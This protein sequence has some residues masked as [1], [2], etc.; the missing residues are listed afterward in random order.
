MT[1]KYDKSVSYSMR[2]K[3]ISFAR[4]SR[5]RYTMVFMARQGKTIDDS[6]DAYAQLKVITDAAQAGTLKPWGGKVAELLNAY[7]VTIDRKKALKAEVTLSFPTTPKNRSMG[8]G[9]RHMKPDGRWAEDFFLFEE[10]VGLTCFY[11]GSQE[12][13]LP[14]YKGTHH[15][16]PSIELQEALPNIQQDIDNLKRQLLEKSIFDSIDL[17]VVLTQSEHLRAIQAIDTE[18]LQTSRSLASRGAPIELVSMQ[19]KPVFDKKRAEQMSR[20][21]KSERLYRLKVDQIKDFYGDDSDAFREA[22]TKLNNL[23]GKVD[24]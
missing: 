1:K 12:D 22:R 9:V 6:K 17:N 2:T 5:L 18:Y 19:I 13:T 23:F 3:C 20:W 16:P 10:N 7:G 24:E 4:G 15:G 21:S 11:R 14:E 8:I